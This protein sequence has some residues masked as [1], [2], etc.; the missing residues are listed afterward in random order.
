VVVREDALYSFLNKAKP[1]NID[2]RKSFKKQIVL[3]AHVLKY[4]DVAT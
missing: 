1:E 2:L 4:L 3:E